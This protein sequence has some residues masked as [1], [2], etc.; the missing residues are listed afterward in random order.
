M[1]I[2]INYETNSGFRQV[3]YY[4]TFH[5]NPDLRDELIKHFFNEDC[6]DDNLKLIRERFFDFVKEHDMCLESAESFSREYLSE[7]SNLIKTL[8]VSL[9]PCD[10]PKTLQFMMNV[11]YNM[12]KVYFKSDAIDLGLFLGLNADP[13][14]AFIVPENET[15]EWIDLLKRYEYIKLCPPIGYRAKPAPLKRLFDDYYAGIIKGNIII[16][17]EFFSYDYDEDEQEMLKEEYQMTELETL[18]MDIVSFKKGEAY[19]SINEIKDLHIYEE[20]LVN[21]LKA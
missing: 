21:N 20:E 16:R 11:F 3:S 9:I 8:T 2:K 10:K 18:M 15:A 7:D 5:R 6:R 1:E 13:E 19:I 17:N 12:V 4:S 14:M